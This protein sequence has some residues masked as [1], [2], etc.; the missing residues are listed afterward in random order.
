G[1]VTAVNP[2]YNEVLGRPCV[3]S[4]ADLPEPADV[5][6]VMLPAPAVAGAVD[7]AGVAG[8]RGVVVLTSDFAEGGREG[9]AS[10]RRVLGAARRHGI[11]LVGPNCMGNISF[12]AR[13]ATSFTMLFDTEPVRPG[14]VAVISQSG[15]IGAS[16]Y[17]LGVQAGLGFSHVIS[18]GN[19]S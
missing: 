17:A 1:T 16:I 6:V 10:Q 7:A 12:H 14:G 11:A 2:G 5:A 19:E 3:H 18:G 9:L 4:V 15:G 13:A 8:I